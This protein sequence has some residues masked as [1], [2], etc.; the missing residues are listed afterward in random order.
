LVW[1]GMMALFTL[2]ICYAI[3]LYTAIVCGIN[4]ISAFGAVMA[5][6][7]GGVICLAGQW[8]LQIATTFVCFLAFGFI[9]TAF[10]LKTDADLYSS[11]WTTFT[12]IF[13]G[14]FLGILYLYS[15]RVGSQIIGFCSGCTVAYVVYTLVGERLSP[16]EPGDARLG[17]CVPLGVLG[18]ATVTRFQEPAL[19]VSSSVLGA[20]QVVLGLGHFIKDFPDAD[21]LAAYREQEQGPSL[22]AAPVMWWV[23]LSLFLSLSVGG[24]CLQL[25]IGA[26]LRGR[27]SRSIQPSEDMRAWTS[28]ESLP[29]ALKVSLARLELV[30]KT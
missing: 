27:C 30:P 19:A 11:G 8:L 15:R 20:A 4:E 29:S 7:I 21:G 28:S 5:M 23:Y 17:L 10:A 3:N 25:P 13:V 12:I 16:D 18:A 6:L 9:A 26:K 22:S 14:L 24:A 1:W 2:T